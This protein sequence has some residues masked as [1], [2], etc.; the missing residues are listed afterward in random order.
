MDRGIMN[1]IRNVINNIVSSLYELADVIEQQQLETN[2]KI[3]QV[4]GQSTHQ[5]LVLQNIASMINSELG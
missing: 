2:T 5:R 4:E 1:N 3:A